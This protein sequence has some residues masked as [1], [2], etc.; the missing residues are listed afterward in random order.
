MALV[1]TQQR[2]PGKPSQRNHQ[3]STDGC[4]SPFRLG[5]IKKLRKGI[6]QAEPTPCELDQSQAHLRKNPR[7][8]SPSVEGQ[9]SG[10]GVQPEPR[11]QEPRRWVILCRGQKLKLC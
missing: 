11:H 7:P 9:G 8:E 10:S 2:L 3:A 5:N 1:S 4:S 6:F